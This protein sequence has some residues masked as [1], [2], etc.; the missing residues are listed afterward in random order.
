MFANALRVHARAN[1][2]NAARLLSTS[3]RTLS[4]SV[5][6]GVSVAGK[7]INSTPALSS[8]RAFSQSAVTL[9]E[10]DNR[11]QKNPPS[12]VLFVGNLP[13]TVTEDIVRE[14]FAPFGQVERVTLQ[15]HADGRPRGFGHVVFASTAQATAAVESAAEEPICI[16]DRDTVLDYAIN[17]ENTPNASIF[18]GN[19]DGDANALRS[20]LSEQQEKIVDI[21]FM[22]DGNTGLPLPSGF[23][24]TDSAET[25]GSVL[26]I[27][28]TV[29][30]ADGKP[31][32]ASY[33]RP[34]VDRS[35]RKKFVERRPKFGGQE[36]RRREHYTSRGDRGGDTWASEDSFNR[37]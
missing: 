31:I 23:V 35:T 9:F 37:R 16:G 4:L 11:R 29:K 27:L 19:F 34:K 25:A 24:R 18:F 22:R 36:G 15:T 14:T 3:T 28:R 21:T 6:R 33:A 30:N 7:T 26:E 5:S 1:A 17:R 13:W 12:N 10:R 2:F 20:I 32:R 8:T